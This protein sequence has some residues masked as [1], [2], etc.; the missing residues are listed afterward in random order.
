MEQVGEP[1]NIE[2]DLVGPVAETEL[3]RGNVVEWLEECWNDGG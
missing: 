2:L 3:C 1:R